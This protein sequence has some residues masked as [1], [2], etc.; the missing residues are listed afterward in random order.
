MGS[1]IINYL[2]YHERTAN[3]FLKDRKRF[4]EASA[5]QTAILPALTDSHANMS[6]SNDPKSIQPSTIHFR[7]D[8]AP[9]TE[10][11]IEIEITK[12]LR[13]TLSRGTGRPKDVGRRKFYDR[14]ACVRHSSKFPRT[15]DT[16]LLWDRMVATSRSAKSERACFRVY[17]RT[18]PSRP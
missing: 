15:Y 16:S 5:A 7:P 14:E 8:N 18:Q 13:P 11:P 6:N 4:L 9:E 12:K 17:R 2:A 1:V 10:S 3:T